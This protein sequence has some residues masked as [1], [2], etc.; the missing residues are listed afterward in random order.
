[1]SSPK[2][3]VFFNEE[4]AQYNSDINS[5]KG[6]LV[7]TAENAG[8]KITRSFSGVI[9]PDFAK[10]KAIENFFQDHSNGCIQVYKIMESANTNVVISLFTDQYCETEAKKSFTIEQVEIQTSGNIEELLEGV[11]Q[12]VERTVPPGRIISDECPIQSWGIPYKEVANEF[13][14]DPQKL[15]EGVYYKKQFYVNEHIDPENPIGN[16]IHTFKMDLDYIELYVTPYA[17]TKQTTT[18]FMRLAYYLFAEGYR[19]VDLKLDFAIN[20]D[21]FTRDK[22][23]YPVRGPHISTVYT[24]GRDGWV[25]RAYSRN[26]EYPALKYYDDGS[27]DIGY[28][29]DNY[30]N[31][32]YA[33]GGYPQLIEEGCMYDRC[34]NGRNKWKDTVERFENFEQDART[35]VGV[36]KNENVLIIVIAEG[37]NLDK[38][39]MNFWELSCLLYAHGATDALNLDGGGS[40]TLVTRDGLIIDDENDDVDLIVNS[41]GNY[42]QPEQVKNHLGIRFK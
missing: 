15:H 30:K 14:D 11:A 9:T 16:I 34:V 5:N 19:T 3:R 1:F 21:G 27:V 8:L 24:G 2:G 18:E 37:D 38:K 35:A 7:I 39:G 26:K 36:D 31:I 32:L 41:N 33:V 13:M 23:P 20:G 6:I 25:Q 17:K 42:P 4:G 29:E 28:L 40:T 22:G 10:M 12:T